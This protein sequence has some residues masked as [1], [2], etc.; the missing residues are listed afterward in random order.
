MEVDHLQA[1]ASYGNDWDD[2]SFECMQKVFP[3]FQE[4][5]RAISSRP[6]DDNV[7]SFVF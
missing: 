7:N 3:F 1:Y 4:S 5:M 2:Q 6:Y